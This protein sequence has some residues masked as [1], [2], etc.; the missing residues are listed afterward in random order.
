MQNGRALA[1][2]SAALCPRNA[3][4]STYEK[5]ALATVE[6][7]KKWRHYFLGA[8]LIIKTD[9]QSLRFITDQ[10]LT[11][12]IQH[13]LMMKLLEFDF[14]IQYKKGTLNKVADALSRKVYQLMSV[15]AA[16]PIWAQDLYDSYQTDPQYKPILEQLLLN[17]TNNFPD[18]T[19]HA[20]VIRF[21][22]KIVVGHNE[23]LRKKLLTALHDSPIGGHS[24][25]SATY[26]RVKTILYWPGLKKFVETYIAQCP[27]CQRAKGEHCLAPGLLE[28]LHVADMAWQHVTMDF[29]EGLPNSGGKD[30]ILVVVDRFTKYAH[31]LPLSHPYSVHSVA[32]AFL[33]NI[34]KLHGPPKLIISDR[35]RIFT[36]QV[37]KDIF[38]GFKTELRYSSAY[39]PQ[40]DGQSKRVNQCLE[41]YLRCMA[42]AEPKKWLSWLPLAEF[43]YNSTYHTAIKRSPFQALYGFPPP[44]I[45]ELAIPGSWNTKAPCSETSRN[46]YSRP[47]RG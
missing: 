12:G 27:I 13:K 39:H 42:S 1:Y 4:M 35:D 26:Q 25:M 31:F 38:T 29:I 11:E 19:Y 8:K 30:V 40:T 28:P 18:Y 9:Q 5:E 46:S 7:L 37:W 33:D 14:T 47:N 44:M 41:I 24:G 6:A 22:G 10:R 2:Y 34:L 21:K 16:I 20:G 17:K 23:E 43:W 3:A 36:S 32:T 15:S 45:S